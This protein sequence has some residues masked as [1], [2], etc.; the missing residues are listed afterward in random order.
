MRS[1]LAVVIAFV[2]GC[3]AAAEPPPRTFAQKIAAVIEHMHIRF[4]ASNG[5]Q[6]GIALGDLDRAHAEARIVAG[7]DE[8][9]LRP[10]WMPYVDNIRAAAWQITMTKDTVTASRTLAYLGRKCAQCHRAVPGAKVEFPKLR[11]PP[12][13]PKLQRQMIHHQ[14]A[15]ARMWEGLIAPS[16]ERWRDGAKG[17]ASARLTI[18][19]EGGELGIA[20]DVARVRLLANRA[21]EAKDLDARAEIY[22]E[23]LAACAH[24]HFTIRDR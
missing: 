17:L 3:E 13:D 4:A 7:L 12:D 23:L 2:V 11:P 24:C 22:G 6:M 21:L 8:R 9:D 14:W 16:D 15:A 19:A 18:A 5:V 1:W 10:E 20:D